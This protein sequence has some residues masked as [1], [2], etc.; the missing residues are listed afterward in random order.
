[1][2]E[3]ISYLTISRWG[4]EGFN[5]IQENIVENYNVLDG[6]L[7][8]VKRDAMTLLLGQFDDSYQN[9]DIFGDLTGT[10][11]LDMFAILLMVFSMTILI[12]K[13]LKNKDSIEIK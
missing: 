8:P 1:M 6:E 3:F 4:V 7:I 11:T 10:L 5:I 2:V 12:Y 13:I 9:K